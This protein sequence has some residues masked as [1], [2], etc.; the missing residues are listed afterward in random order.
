M[1]KCFYDLHVHSALSPCASIEMTPNNI[2]NM[3]CLKGLD[4]LAI[5]DHN[6]AKNIEAIMD[7]AKNQDIIVIPGVE[8]ETYEGI[9]MLCYFQ[10]LTDVLLFDKIVYQNIPRIQNKEDLCGQQLIIN[11]HDQIICKEVKMLMNS[12]HLKLNE[13]INIV[14]LLN[15]LVFPAHIN[16]YANSIVT[17][18]GFI[19]EDLEIT[20]IEISK[21]D[22]LE[23]YQ[24]NHLFSKYRIIQNSDAHYLGDIC[25]KMNYLNL[26]EKSIQAFFE[27]FGD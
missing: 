20:G 13:L 22:Q 23:R 10:T 14:R 1:V 15:G 12:T 5:T 9:H 8:V 2:V 25:E 17:I 11:H 6:S 24:D 21:G 18:L 19:P 27:S 26:R 7:V 4:L 16:R 3:A